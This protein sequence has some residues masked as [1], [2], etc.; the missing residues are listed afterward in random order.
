MSE[1]TKGSLVQKDIDWKKHM[2]YL[3]PTVYGRT[4]PKAS[5]KSYPQFIDKKINI[6]NAKNALLT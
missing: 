3:S 4:H 6:L 5:L 2:L 1:D